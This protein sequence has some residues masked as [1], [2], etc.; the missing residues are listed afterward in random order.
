M[1]G[2]FRIVHSIFFLFLS[3]CFLAAQS[4]ILKNQDA[5]GDFIERRGN[6][7]RTASGKPGPKYW[8]NYADYMIEATLDT[9]THTITGKV[10]I[11]YL[12]NSPEDLEFIWLQLEQNRF[13]D[14]S[15]GTLTTPLQGDRYA[16]NTDGGFQISNVKASA[17]RRN[18]LQEYFITDT[19]MQIF[20]N[21]PVRPFGGRAKITMNFTFKIPEDGMDRMGRMPTEKGHVYAIAQWYPKVAVFDD[22][23]GWNNLPYLGAGEFYL[24]YGNFDYKITVPFDHIVVGSGEL[25]NRKE[26]LSKM[27]LDRWDQA[28]K[29]E[30]TI[31]LIQENEVGNIALTRPKSSGTIT[32]H[33]K[34]ENTRDVAFASSRAFMWDAARMNLSEGRKGM[35]HSVYPVESA[36]REAWGRS[37]EYTKAAIEFYD[38][39]YYPYPYP[40]AINVACNVA[41]ME[42]PAVSFCHY[43]SKGQSLWNV[44]DHEFGHN[45]FPMIVGSNE[46]KYVWLDEGLN[47]FLNHYSTRA[48]NNGE[49]PTILDQSRR[50]VSWLTNDRREPIMTYPEVVDRNNL[51]MTGYYKPG[52]GLILL[53]EYILEPDR[54]DRALRVY[55]D[56]WAY[57][58]PDPVDFFNTIENVTGEDLNWFWKGWFYGTGNIDLSIS[59]VKNVSDGFLISLKNKGDIPMPV[60]M[61]VRYEDDT[62]EKVKL[63]VEI[64]YRGP[65]WNYLHHTD[66]TI[67]SVEIDPE[68]ILPDINGSNDIWPAG[69]YDQ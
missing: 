64:W 23:S 43:Q 24:E 50:F 26:V 54:F 3:T 18:I 14:T 35:A 66:K 2:P 34:M 47:M 11:D 38:K 60:W 55:I 62:S 28:E 33:F 36:G 29:S 31:F 7:Y 30:E 58:H 1:T 40:H 39:N 10:T 22:I 20:L 19:R 13:T 5:F 69:F 8:Q 32:W 25:V 57:K 63:P 37:T 41:G 42:Y 68:N 21:E 61:E 53:R 16:S 67:I 51:G 49:Y 4:D 12:N 9:N 56:R 45:W 48:F 65:E 6:E 27:L 46:R 59:D 44:T 15:R 52:I 17:N